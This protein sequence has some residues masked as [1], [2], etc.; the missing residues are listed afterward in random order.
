MNWPAI[1]KVRQW[2]AKR[3]RLLTGLVGAAVEESVKLVPGAGLA[4]RII[5][6]LTKHGVERLAQPA[7]LPE[8]KPAGETFGQDQLDQLNTYLE[9]LSASYGGLLDRLEALGLPTN[10]KSD[11][12]LA[13][14][15]R[16]A[17][18][19]HQD[20]AD[21]FEACA[22]QVRVQTLSLAC[23][24]GKL[25]QLFHEQLRVN[26]G[27]EDIKAILADS[28]LL[29]DWEEFRRARPEAIRAI[30]RADV[31]FLK[32]DRE[33]GA[34]QLLDLMKQRGVGGP[35]LCRALGIR[36]LAA[37]RVEQ[38]RECL[39]LSARAVVQAPPRGRP[40][41]L[42]VAHT[43][44][45][46]STSD[47][48]GGMPPWRSLPRFFV[49]DRRYRIEAEIGRGGMAS[50]YKAT[51]I[52]RV[53]KG[54][55][56]AL[57]VP[58]PD[59]LAD[60]ETAARF[61][62][63]IEVSQRLTGQHPNIVQTLGYAIFEDPHTGQELYALVLEYLP[64]VSLA[65]IL[66]H[67]KIRDELLY[68]DIILKVLRPVCQ[69][70]ACAHKLGVLHRDLKP[71]NVMLLS[72][73]DGQWVVKLMDFGIARVLADSRDS[74]R[75]TRL[76]GTPAYL[77]P[78]RDFDVTSDVYLAG[79]L[80]LEALTFDPLGDAEGRADCP[81]GW[82]HLIGD[83]MSRLKSRRP[84]TV[85][86][87]LER[88]EEGL[89]P[90]PLAKA[91]LS[92]A[93]PAVAKR[94]RALFVESKPHR[95]TVSLPRAITN[96]IGMRLVLVPAGSFVMGSPEIEK[97]RSDNEGPQHE[98]VI[99]QPFYLGIY[100]VTQYEYLKVGLKR[101]NPSYFSA[102]GEGKD[103]VKGLDTSEFPVESVG[104]DMA[105]KF[106]RRLSERPE[107]RAA[108]RV[109]RLPTEAEWEYACRGGVKEY[110]VFHFGNSLS[111]EQANFDGRS[112]YGGAKK[113]PFLGR[114]S[115]VGSYPPNGFGLY[116]M[117]GNV[118]EWCADC[119]DWKYY[120]KS[121]RE[122]PQGP[123][124]NRRADRVGRGG[125][126]G[127]DGQFCRSAYRGWN[128]P[129][130]TDH[131]LGFR[132]ALTLEESSSRTDEA[133]VPGQLG[134]ACKVSTV[135]DVLHR[136]YDRLKQQPK[137]QETNVDLPSLLREAQRDKADLSV[138][139]FH[140]ALLDLENNRAVML[141]Y[142]TGSK[143]VPDAD[144]CIQRHGKLI[145]Y[146]YWFRD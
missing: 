100:P 22:C 133:A 7:A 54:K 101:R 42:A 5:G 135:I 2:T 68:P 51:C 41:M 145:Y 92:A 28:P 128:R 102:K 139:D 124:D 65:Q 16:Q 125:G 26:V 31:C 93:I 34:R 14:L 138:A 59:L 4:V 30:N 141:N 90:L 71:H 72:G 15:V 103:W 80:L 55:V 144:K 105:V 121:P 89:N 36:A 18:Q 126:W 104:W 58:A 137:Y 62:Q 76:V 47:S 73:A 45:R 132:V 130:F 117:H 84:R 115:K 146:I 21:Q 122:N 143:G 43:L 77:P 79:N 19:S 49:V 60:E 134:S 67:F 64:G 83:A 53:Q 24:E 37:G 50:V 48:P 33:G 23:I 109:Y 8:V 120:A 46:L 6:E 97:D 86:E 106:C 61:I 69:A 52:D 56:V 108:G 78:D 119:Y 94:E 136:S 88:L 87:F 123:N 140:Q 113:G 116:D 27:L 81:E 85:E 39:E 29:A 112:P 20:L 91:G 66:A 82:R 131:A 17:L 57:K 127:N 1:E 110:Q 74:R 63:E 38:A 10:G 32:G 98:V 3:Q 9:Q 40:T 70:L 25:G 96:S 95:I 11:E 12:Q 44:A 107:E 142:H 118:W 114:T 111:S 75:G 129:S 99:S 13:T 35:T